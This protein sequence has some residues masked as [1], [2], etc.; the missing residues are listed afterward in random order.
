MTDGPRE[1]GLSDPWT[2]GSQESEPQEPRVEAWWNPGSRSGAAGSA[3]RGG[4][5]NRA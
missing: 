3:G 4:S 2:D 1:P 5:G